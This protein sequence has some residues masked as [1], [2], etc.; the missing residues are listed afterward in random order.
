MRL[1]LEVLAAQVARDCRPAKG[2]PRGHPGLW[3][4]RMDACLEGVGSAVSVWWVT[5]GG[6]RCCA[7]EW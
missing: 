3:E 6:V 2:R 4:F 7:V 5:L 1:S